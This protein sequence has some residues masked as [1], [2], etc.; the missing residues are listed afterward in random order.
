MTEPLQQADHLLKAQRLE[1]ERDGRTLFRDLSFSIVPGTLT[2]VEGPNGSGKTT[3]L[4]ILAGLNDNWSGHI[5][6]CGRPRHKQWDSVRRNTLYLGHRPGIKGVLTPMENLQALV[7]GRQA[8][9]RD[10]LSRALVQV[11]LGPWQ[12]VPCEHLS[13]G[14]KRRV[15]LARLLFADEPLWLLDEA[16]TALDVEA[17]AAVERLLADRVRDGGAVVMTTHHQPALDDMQR[18]LLG[19]GPGQPAAEVSDEPVAEVSHG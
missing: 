19:H 13:A 5:H 7:A 4:R 3:L 17:V 2:R 18:I 15:A 6:W 8:V 14:Q 16:F 9:S 1:C 12:N 11:G 10:V